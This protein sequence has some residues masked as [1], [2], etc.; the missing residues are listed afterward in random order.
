MKSRAPALGFIFLTLFLDVL[1]IGLIIPILPRLV[2]TLDRQGVASGSYVVGWLLAL[3]AL[4]QFLFAPILGALSDWYGRRP[5]ILLALLGG[6]IDYLLLALAPT[7]PWFFLG[8]AINGIT[9]A[10]ITAATAYIADI[11]PPERRAGNFGLLGAAFGL[12]FTL[13]PPLGGWLGQMDLR[14]PFYVAAGLTL[15][16]WLYGYFI[17]PESLARE[18]RRRFSWTR[19]NP[20]GS[21]S[22]LQRYPSVVR[23]AIVLFLLQMAQT[24]LRGAWVQYTGY[25]FGWSPREVGWSL[26]VVGLGAVV[27]QGGLAR[28]LIPALGEIRSLW[29]SQILGILAMLGYGLA[30]DAWMLYVA[31]VIGSFGGLG[32]RAAQAMVSRRIPPNEQG[33]VQGALTALASIAY[34]LGPLIG[35]RTFGWFIQPSAPVFLPGAPFLVGAGFIVLALGCTVVAVRRLAPAPPAAA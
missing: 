35:A 1:G 34:V 25:R 24:S 16:N 9:G 21:L 2:E 4:M 6:W 5:V 14:L 19:A 30:P 29:M 8:R 7:L 32:E 33:T 27:V 23:F 18:N 20:F 15:A 22:A 10:N 28:R 13:G 12:G 31:L 11:T 26:A 17:L 3:Y